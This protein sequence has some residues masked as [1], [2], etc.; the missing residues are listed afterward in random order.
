MISPPAPSGYI[1]S[2]E[3]FPEIFGGRNNASD[4]DEEGEP[5]LFAF[6]PPQIQRLPKIR[7]ISSC[8]SPNANAQ[9]TL[10]ASRMESGGGGG[11]VCNL[12]PLITN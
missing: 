11:G 12:H 7:Q 2:W 4:E 6:K 3:T 1:G 9:P 10:D 5:F 8:P